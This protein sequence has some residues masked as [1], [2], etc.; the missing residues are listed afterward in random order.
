M[1]LS[2]VSGTAG[3]STW[4]GSARHVTALTFNPPTFCS[5]LL[6]QIRARPQAG[7]R[8]LPADSAGTDSQPSR[9]ATWGQFTSLPHHLSSEQETGTALSSGVGNAALCLP[10]ATPQRGCALRVPPSS[11]ALLSR[12][13]PALRPRSVGELAARSTPCRQVVRGS[14]CMQV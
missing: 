10:L 4:R 2:T 12:F 8:V 13:L 9:D 7:T 1:G 6:G 5:Q 3:C 11:A 14:P